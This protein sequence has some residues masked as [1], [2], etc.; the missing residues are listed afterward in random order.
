MHYNNGPTILA[1]LSLE[2]LNVDD[3]ILYNLKGAFSTCAYFS[4]NDNN[5]MRLR[6]KIEKSSDGLFKYHNRVV[7]PRPANV[8]IKALL[9]ESHDN[10][11]QPNYRRLMASLLK[12]YWC[13]NMTLDC[14]LYCQNCV[15]CN[16]AKPDRRGG[17]S[18]QPFGI[19]E[20]PW[21]IVGID[22]VTDLPKS[23]LYGHTIVLL[24]F[25]T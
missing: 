9:I 23:G 20:Y 3:N 22:Y 2:A 16:R 8:L 24:W 6:Q 15:I 12:R 18:L 7:T 4:T 10:D 5:D 17:A 21:E 1:L 11:G 25:V 14:K 19:P 13:D